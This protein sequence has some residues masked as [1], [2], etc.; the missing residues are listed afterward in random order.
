[1]ALADPT[2]DG[3]ADLVDR[4]RTNAHSWDNAYSAVWLHGS[5]AVVTAAAALDRAQT[6]L[7]YDAQERLFTLEDWYVTRAPMRAAFEKFIEVVRNELD[8][9]HVPATYFPALARQLPS[10]QSEQLS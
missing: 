5:A 6:E 2:I 7:F 3:F 10:R 4:V 1:M 9:E 8:L